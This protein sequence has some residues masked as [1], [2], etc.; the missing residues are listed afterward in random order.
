[1]NLVDN[2]TEVFLDDWKEAGF[3]STDRDSIINVLAGE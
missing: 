3:L 2:V 1:M